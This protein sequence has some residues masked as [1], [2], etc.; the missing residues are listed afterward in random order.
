MDAD[1]LYRPV[2]ACALLEGSGDAHGERHSAVQEALARIDAID[3]DVRAMTAVIGRD[4][5]LARAA[6]ARG[7]LAGLPVVVKDIFD[8][9]DLPTAYGSPIYADHRPASDAA[10]VTLLRRAGG[11]VVG[12]AT[13]S[14]FAY[15]APTVTRNPCDPARTPG[16]SSAGS[17]AAVAAGIAPFAIGSQ[18][19]G[20]TIRPASFCGIAG[21]KPT[22]G[23]L[24]T[25]G[26]KCFSWSLDTVGLF[27]AGVRD[28]AFLAQALSGR[29]LAVTAAPERPVFGVPVD[30]PWAAPS[31]NATAAVDAA[32][33]AIR[34]AGGSVKPVR[35]DAW[36]AELIAAH[37]V[38]QGYEAWRTLGYEYDRHRPALSPLLG[39]F[40]DRAGEIDVGAYSNACEQMQRAKGRLDELFDGM[41]AM[42][43]PGAPDEAPEGLAST[44]S[45]AFNRN[46]TLL[47]CPCVN[48]P[49][50][51]GASGMPVGV[52]VVGRPGDDAQVLAA[53]V[54]VERSIAASGEAAS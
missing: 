50:L 30:Y 26:M 31:A 4:D 51:R 40:L 11:V 10:V 27:A 13:T 35:F 17:A 7:P 25:T 44:G 6:A 46:W 1:M 28:V 53:A 3:A 22:F 34:Q 32:I 48:V 21:Y 15:M 20:S 12:K 37:G 54:F 14:E 47:G 9:A 52:Q 23:M 38:I 29:A 39:E 36:V 5:A 49:G 41:T 8:T 45:P 42:L 43:T 33:R 16:G 2:S 19:G 18:T 24:P